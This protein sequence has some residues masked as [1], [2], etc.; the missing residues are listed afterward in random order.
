LGDSAERQHK[1]GD[2]GGRIS[3]LLVHPRQIENAWPIVEGWI[4]QAVLK[5]HSDQSVQEIK[6]C[7]ANGQMQLFI[8]HNEHRVPFGCWILEFTD[9]ARGKLC[10]IY[11]CAGRDFKKWRHLMADIKAHARDKG[12]TLLQAAGRP[13]WQRA[14]ARDG[15]KRLRVILETR[16][17]D[18]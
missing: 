3:F 17:D 2:H 11:L 12:C 1:L 13:G 16:L 6:W 8:V 14:L 4:F 9:T 15:F 5:A 7:L 10:N 18:A